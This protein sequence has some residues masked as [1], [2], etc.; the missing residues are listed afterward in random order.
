MGFIDI[1]AFNIAMLA[2]QARRLIQGSLSLFFR[3]YKARYIPNY[4]FMEAEMGNNPS[5][6]WR[7]LLET[8]S[9]TVWKVGDGKSIKIDD[10]RWLLHPPQFRPEA[11]KNMR[12]T[13]STQIQGNGTNSY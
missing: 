1:H 13:S 7:S 5:F 12:V 8:R 10:H 2:K 9:D 4:S 3:V 6:V 11:D